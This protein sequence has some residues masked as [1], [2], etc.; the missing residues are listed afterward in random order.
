[1]KELRVVVTLLVRTV[2]AGKNDQGVAVK[3]GLFQAAH[4]S[5]H[6]AVQAR[7]QSG[8]TLLDIGPVAAFVRRV[9]WHIDA[10]RVSG[11]A[12][13][14]GVRTGKS[15]TE[16]ERV[17]VR[18][19][20]EPGCLLREKIFHENFT[21]AKPVRGQKCLILIVPEI[22]R[23]RIMSVLLIEEAVKLI[24]ATQIRN[25]A[26]PR[27]TEAPLAEKGGAVACLFQQFRQSGFL[28]IQTRLRL[29]IPAH[30]GVAG[31]FSCHQAA[32]GWRANGGTGI[33]LREADTARSQLVYVGSADLFLAVTAQVAI[34]EV[35]GKNENN[36]GLCSRLSRQIRESGSSG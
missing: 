18:P 10:V 32:A 11:S 4:H 15:Q 16:E 30:R 2:V 35:V 5:A 26:S 27:T 25:A 19:L 20:Q 6:V 23:E 22:F 28:R 34:A 9:R 31:V 3:P 12:L 13:V 8:E 36:V 14:I 7:N 33:G 17:W 21:A 24:E 29:H 1:M